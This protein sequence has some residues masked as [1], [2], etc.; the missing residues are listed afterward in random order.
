MR[1]ASFVPGT[2]Q[3]YDKYK[4][5]Y[6]QHVVNLIFVLI[7]KISLTTSRKAKSLCESLLQYVIDIINTIIGDEQV[8]KMARAQSISLTIRTLKIT[9]TLVL[10]FS[11]MSRC[12]KS[13]RSV[14]RK[15]RIGASQVEHHLLVFKQRCCNSHT[16]SLN[17]VFVEIL[18]SQTINF[19]HY[20]YSF[21]NERF[22]HLIWALQNQNESVFGLRL[23]S[24]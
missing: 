13:L 19:Y 2:H 1:L 20:K 11:I 18:V 17:K 24:R 21:A 9:L 6:I 10:I 3:A 8:N 14:Y 22:R 12:R 23:C 4:S 16:S 5:I 15:Y 7:T